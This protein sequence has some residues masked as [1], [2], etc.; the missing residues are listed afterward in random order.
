MEALS[1]GWPLP[2]PSGSPRIRTLGDRKAGPRNRDRPERPARDCGPAEFVAGAPTGAIGHT[3]GIQ[4]TTCRFSGNSAAGTHSWRA[5]QQPDCPDALD[6]DQCV[7]VQALRLREIQRDRGP[8]PLYLPSMPLIRGRSPPH[9]IPANP[10][11]Q[12][13]APG[14]EPGTSPTRIMG[15]TWA[16]DGKAL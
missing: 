4:P 12:I 14:F 3:L 13:G 15:E 2:V 10:D 1:F 5:D 11:K 16:A 9:K 8:S 7:Y 6:G